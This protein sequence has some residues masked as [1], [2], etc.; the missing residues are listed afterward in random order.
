LGNDSKK[1]QTPKDE[2]VFSL[3]GMLLLRVDSNLIPHLPLLDLREEVKK[4]SQPA[5]T[6]MSQ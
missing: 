2:Q 3:I 6:D 4:Y 5:T 1:K